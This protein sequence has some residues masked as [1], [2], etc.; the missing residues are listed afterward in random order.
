MRTTI[1]TEED[2]DDAEEWEYFLSQCG[3]PTSEDTEVDSVTI[4]YTTK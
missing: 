3:I 4:S 1:Y 2:F